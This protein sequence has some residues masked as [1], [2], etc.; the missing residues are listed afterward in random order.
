MAEPRSNVLLVDDRPDNLL[1]LEAILEPLGQ[2]LVRATSG[3]E[4]L[5]CLL[6]DDF[7]AILLDVQMPSL[8][9]FETARHIKQLDRTSDIPI[10]FLS[11]ISREIHHQLR[12]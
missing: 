2:N 8:D 1:A 6:R 11:A 7:A 4:A 3:E 5:R 10:I 9:G 12:G